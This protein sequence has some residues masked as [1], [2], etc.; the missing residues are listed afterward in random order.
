[1]IC[2]GLKGV[3][4]LNKRAR[5]FLP[6]RCL[7]NDNRILACLPPDPI[8]QS[9]PLPLGDGRRHLLVPIALF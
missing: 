8:S 9:V 1:M 7:P 2:L 4:S 5:P 3:S 6:A